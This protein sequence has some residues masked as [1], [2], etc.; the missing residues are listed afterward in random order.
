M[1]PGCA[2]TFILC[3]ALPFLSCPSARLLLLLHLQLLSFQLEL[4]S[5]DVQK[6]YVSLDLRQRFLASAHLGDDPGHGGDQPRQGGENG[7]GGVRG[8]P[9]G[10]A[11]DMEREGVNAHDEQ[12]RDKAAD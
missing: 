5:L 9:F 11:G 1:G 3:P 4:L 10:I 12:D 7:Q 8:A 6:G 2:K